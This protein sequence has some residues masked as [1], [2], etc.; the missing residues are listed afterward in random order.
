ME[1]AADN[2]DIMLVDDEPFVLEVMK[3]LFGKVN[4]NGKSIKERCVFLPSGP[5]AVKLIEERLAKGKD[6]VPQFK[7]VFMDIFLKSQPGEEEMDGF[8]AVDA[9]KTEYMK[10]L[11]TQPYVVG[12]SSNDWKTVEEEASDVAMDKFLQKP[13]T[14]DQLQETIEE[15]LKKVS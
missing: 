9:I 10:E 5:Q 11:A 14:L 1:G 3:A 12:I 2:P 15:A 7:V 6:A 4:I 8:E 13:A